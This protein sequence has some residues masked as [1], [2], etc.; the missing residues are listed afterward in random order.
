MGANRESSKI[1][2]PVASG[3]LGRDRVHIHIGLVGVVAAVAGQV[4][5]VVPQGAPVGHLTRGQGDVDRAFL[6][7][8]W[9]ADYQLMFAFADIQAPAFEL[10]PDRPDE[11]IAGAYQGERVLVAASCLQHGHSGPLLLAAPGTGVRP[12]PAG[13]PE[14]R[15]TRHTPACGGASQRAGNPRTGASTGPIQ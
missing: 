12:R 7:M 3:E 2:E 9:A 6:W 8:P 5:Q 10:F 1:G 11:F 15:D 4:P 14:H 13:P